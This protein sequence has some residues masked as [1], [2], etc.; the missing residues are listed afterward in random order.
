MAHFVATTATAGV[1]SPTDKQIIDDLSGPGTV[2]SIVWFHLL[3]QPASSGTPAV[4]DTSSASYI[5]KARFIF[6][7][8][9]LNIPNTT[10]SGKLYVRGMVSAN[11][12]DVRL[13]NVT[14][15]VELAAINFTEL[16]FTTKTVNLSGLPASGVKVVEVQMRR[17]VVGTTVTVE[18]ASCDFLLSA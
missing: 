3:P 7:F 18:T 12:G 1:L 10:L 9:R 13:Y 4:A 15:A 6:N 11:N 17:N 14:D 8:D 2:L 16:T 5:S